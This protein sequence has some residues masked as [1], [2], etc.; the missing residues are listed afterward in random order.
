MSF[1]Y[2]V[3]A[4]FFFLIYFICSAT[5]QWFANVENLQQTAVKSLKGVRMVPEVCK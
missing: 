3:K 5:A 1:I 4:F 2:I